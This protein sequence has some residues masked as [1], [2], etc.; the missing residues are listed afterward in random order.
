MRITP[1]ARDCLSGACRTKCSIPQHGFGLSGYAENSRIPLNLPPACTPLL[2]RLFGGTILLIIATK[3]KGTLSFCRFTTRPSFLV[4]L[5]PLGD[6]P[7]PCTYTQAP[8]AIFL[9]FFLKK[10]NNS[11]RVK[12]ST[13]QRPDS[14]LPTPQTG[15]ARRS[16]SP[17]RL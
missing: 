5:C 4:F 2:S 16:P 14:S 13:W 3:S 6:F 10:I 8:P 11:S 15:L 7:P 1:S 9:I 17:T 12:G